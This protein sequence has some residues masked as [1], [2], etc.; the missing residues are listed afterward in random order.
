[1]IFDLH[2]L[3]PP[4]LVLARTPSIPATDGGSSS[5]FCIDLLSDPAYFFKS[6][7]EHAD[8]ATTQPPPAGKNRPSAAKQSKKKG[9]KNKMH[10]KL[11]MCESI[12]KGV[13]C[14]FGSSCTFAHCE[15]ELELTTLRE[16]EKAGLVDIMTFRT[17]PCLDHVMT[18]SW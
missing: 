18:G 15:S 6:W 3:D 11:E 16:R 2:C 9:G 12:L 1:M 4:S 5:N 8:G 14:N 7:Y 17:R 10:L 13:D